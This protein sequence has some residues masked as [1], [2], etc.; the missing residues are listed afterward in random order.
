M[1]LVWHT[2]GMDEKRHDQATGPQTGVFEPDRR[3]DGNPHAT[4]AD[5]GADAESCLLSPQDFYEEMTAR[6]DVR[7]ILARLARQ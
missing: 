6:E 5:N 3:E 1:D 4:G 7:E 2:R